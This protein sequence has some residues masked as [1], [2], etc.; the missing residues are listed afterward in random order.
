MRHQFWNRWSEEILS[1]LQTLSN[2]KI[3]YDRQP[4]V[5]D[6][7]LVAEDIATPFNGPQQEYSNFIMEMM[8]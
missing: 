4:E 2:G 7:V 3:V 5:Y 1:Q 6:L 8:T